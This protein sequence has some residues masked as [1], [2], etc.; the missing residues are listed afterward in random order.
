MCNLIL[1]HYCLKWTPRQPE[2]QRE[3]VAL[4]RA[5]VGGG[6]AAEEASPALE[7]LLCVAEMGRIHFSRLL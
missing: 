2:V 1:F 3:P 6:V 4:H 7:V 5:H